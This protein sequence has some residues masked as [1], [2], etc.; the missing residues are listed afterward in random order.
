MVGQSSRGVLDKFDRLG[1]Q[2][3]PD[4][5]V[6]GRTF[7]LAWLAIDAD[8]FEEVGGLRREHQ[9]VDAQAL[10][11]REAG[12]LVVP[13]GVVAAGRTERAQYAASAR[14]SPP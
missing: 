10:V 14:G 5:G 8:R 6:V 12:A 1:R 13:E 7:Q 3:R 11:A 4:R 9:V 2:A